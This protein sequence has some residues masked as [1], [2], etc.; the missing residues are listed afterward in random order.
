[1]VMPA[2]VDT[3]ESELINPDVSSSNYNHVIM[4]KKGFPTPI[5]LDIFGCK[6]CRWINSYMCPHKGDVT[7]MKHHVNGI[8]SQRYLIP[9]QLQEDGV[10]M[11][12]KQMLQVKGLMDADFFSQYVQAQVQNNKR[13]VNDCLPWEKLKAEI[14]NN[15]R[16]QD[17][18]SKITMKKESLDPLQFAR[19]L[20]ET[21]EKVVEGEI[22]DG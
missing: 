14:L 18:G 20:R 1:M 11:T 15:M 13:D 21:K 3:V 16:R 19:L 6:S 10:R 22:K 5:V 8:C 4:S 7:H 12:G 9:I 2:R 17:E